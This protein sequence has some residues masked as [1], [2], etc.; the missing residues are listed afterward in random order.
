MGRGKVGL[1]ALV[2]TVAV[3]GTTAEASAAPA[4]NARCAAVYDP[5]TRSFPYT[6]Q[7]NRLCRTGSTA[8]AVLIDVAL[9]ALAAHK[10]DLGSVLSFSRMSTDQACT[11]LGNYAEALGA[12]TKDT[13][14]RPGELMN[15]H[16]SLFGTD[17]SAVE[18]T[19]SLAEFVANSWLGHRRVGRTDFES[20]LLRK[21]LVARMTK[22]FRDLGLPRSHFGNEHGG[23]EGLPAGGGLPKLKDPRSTAGEMA[24]FW[25][26]ASRRPRF[27]E[28]TGFRTKRVNT[29]LDN[30]YRF[31]TFNKWYG[32]YPGIL[33]DKNGGV[34][35]PGE[36][37]WT[38]WLGSA[39]RL[40]RVLT[41]S[42]ME[43]ADDGDP[44]TYNEAANDVG[45]VLAHSF[46]RIFTPRRR[47]D[48][49]GQGS[50]AADVDVDCGAG[51][52]CVTAQ[53]SN[54][55]LRVAVWEPNFASRR[56]DRFAEVQANGPEVGGIA[57]EQ[58]GARRAVTAEGRAGG[59]A[60]RSWRTDVPGTPGQTG[61]AETAPGAHPGRVAMTTAGADTVVLAYRRADGR[62][63]VEAWRVA[64]NGSLTQVGGGAAPEVA[65]PETIEV[66]A[67]S[68][69]RTFVTLQ[70]TGARQ[71]LISWALSPA[72]TLSRTGDSGE[73]ASSGVPGG[74]TRAGPDRWASGTQGTTGVEFW[75]RTSGGTGL[76]RVGNAT[77]FPDPQSLR[78]RLG[79]LGSM[80]A[81]A[82]AETPRGL[83]LSPVEVDPEYDANGVSE[84][85]NV[86]GT[87]A[88]GHAPGGH[89]VALVRRRPD[90]GSDFVVAVTTTGA[91]LKLLNWRVG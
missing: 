23:W 68:A 59:I 5:D 21:L 90:G 58:L 37:T 18:P 87:A 3:L 88:A 12:D 86:L 34:S 10:V 85:Y 60:L 6:K 71:R 83:V 38:S 36:P 72:G 62:L 13:Y 50:P 14:A 40:G 16:Y 56:T 8:K 79:D 19:V 74:L 49:D 29:L 61:V 44:T 7:R 63:G 22:R 33:G 46:A 67:G 53:R 64:A 2:A 73:A 30:A 81:L 9:G 1:A 28:V 45:L 82:V 41:F 11:C 77:T 15:F 66:A 69:T 47:G 43:A 51:R 55:R 75:Q 31:Q 20:M 65:L 24:R 70:H 27:L 84:A 32:Y 17:M 25:A 57:V 48:S 52:R 76:M 91:R 54:R 89:Q 42:V 35:P 80:A 4:I 39:R 26:A 78:L